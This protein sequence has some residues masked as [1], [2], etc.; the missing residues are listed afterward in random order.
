MAEKREASER[1]RPKETDP[2]GKLWQESGV[3]HLSFSG[4]LILFTSLL[5]TPIPSGSVEESQ[6]S[7][8]GLL[9]AQIEQN[10]VGRV[11]VHAGE[12]M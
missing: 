3:S 10:F 2:T 9:H 12:Q 1:C 8:S 5:G 4:T 7:P 11:V 6:L